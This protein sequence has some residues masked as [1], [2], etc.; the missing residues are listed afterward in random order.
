M[1]SSTVHRVL[2]RH[3]LN[4]LDHL[5]R[6]TRAPIRRI[7]M[8]RPGELVHVDIKK[9][10]RI[11]RGGGW[12]VNG[13]AQERGRW[14]RTKVGYAFVHTAIDGYS[15][16]A[17]SEV[18][19]DEQ[20]VTAAGFWLRAASF[21]AAHDITIERVLT[22]NGSCYRSRDFTAALGDTI[23]TFTQPYRPATNGKVERFN[24]T[25]LAEWAYTKPYRSDSARR[26][27]LPAW[28]HIYNHHRPHT[29]LGGRPPATRVPNLSGQ[30][31]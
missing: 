22:D 7:E 2:V 25:L 5:D 3:Q 1:P 24:R 10:G 18:L 23:H 4:R 21:F 30:N 28:L 26:A 13:R 17:Y 20:G 16:L 8:S 27:A 14:H 19:A 11:P 29:A 9:L 31:T 12:R 6:V 15:R